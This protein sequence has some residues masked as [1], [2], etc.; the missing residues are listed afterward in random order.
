[1]KTKYNDIIIGFGFWVTNTS[2]L[3]DHYFKR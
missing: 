3:P 1:M 2:N